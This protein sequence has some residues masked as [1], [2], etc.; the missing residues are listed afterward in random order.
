MEYIKSDGSKVIIDG[1]IQYINGLK[2]KRII[3]AN[4]AN[5]AILGGYLSSFNGSFSNEDIGVETGVFIVNAKIGNVDDAYLLLDSKVKDIDST[6]IVEL[7]RVILEVVDEYFNDFN[8]INNRMN[9]YYPMELEESMNNK[10]SNLKGTGAAMCVERAA[11]SQNLL[12]H[13]G[14]NSFY[15]SSGIIK[16]NNKEVHSY[17][18]IE[19]YDKY[20]IFDSS[21]PNMINNMANPLICEIDYNTFDLL[22]SPISSLGVSVGVSHYNPYRDTDVS[23]IYDSSRSNYLDVDTFNIKNNKYL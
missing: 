20:Y 19:F 17:N 3:G 18:L 8:N 6:N 10:I 2:Q 4:Y 7:S 22:S 16:N 5:G 23:I 21:I 9:Y 15:K 13:L 12:S 11:L 1:D 14:I